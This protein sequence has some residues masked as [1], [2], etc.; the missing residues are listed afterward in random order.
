MPSESGGVAY[1]A[2][3]LLEGLAAEGVEVDCFVSGGVD[4][5][6]SRLHGRP[7]LNI[8]TRA[9]G[10][11][12]DRWYS[13]GAIAKV[14]TGQLARA[15]AQN[16]L[17]RQLARRHAARP[18]DVLYQ[19][20]QPELFAVRWLRRRLPPI[21]VHPEVHAAG[22]LRWHRRER[23]LAARGE[24]ERKRIQVDAI[25]AARSLVQRSDLALTAAVIC[26]SRAFAEEV[27]RDYAVPSSKLHVVP[28]PIDLERFAYEPGGDASVGPLTVLFVSRMSV[29][30]GV[31]MVVDLSHRLD[32]LAGEV[33]VVLV[34]GE[35]LWSD[36]RP[37]LADLNPRVGSWSGGG[38]PAATVAA[39][40]RG[41]HVLVQPSHYEPFAITVAEALAAGVPV[42]AS[43]A[44][45]AT[46]GIDATCCRVFAAGDGA[47]FEQAVRDLLADLRSDR[48]ADIRARA[49]AEAERAYAPQVVAQRVVEVLRDVTAAG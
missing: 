42:V 7:G 27:A 5:V 20:S 28:N 45:G 8:V 43:D 18:Y 34:G 35:S 23:A 16:A 26:P 11:E 41:A 1:V 24:S 19:F 39:R 44:V 4:D 29:R 14:L 47:A 38:E 48:G 3:Q 17:V 49:R 9:S 12:S 21:V 40:L 10:W 33:E 15:H 25:L 13:R 6:P 31:E 36:Y 32:D 30:K 46:E 2:T 37:L 22:E